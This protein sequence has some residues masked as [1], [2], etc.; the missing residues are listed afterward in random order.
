MNRKTFFKTLFGIPALMLVSCTTA[1]KSILI[2]N[3]TVTT[4]LRITSDGVEVLRLNSD[5]R[6]G[7]KIPDPT[8]SL[9]IRG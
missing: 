1:K 2:A 9:Y 5:S 8:Y 4:D 7:L 6:I 3:N